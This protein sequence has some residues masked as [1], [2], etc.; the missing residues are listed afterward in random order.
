M[1]G[2]MCSLEE[3]EVDNMKKCN[4]ITGMRHARSKGSF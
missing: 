1:I 2:L 4:W 3:M